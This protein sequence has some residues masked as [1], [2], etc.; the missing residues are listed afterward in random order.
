MALP[1]MALT[2]IFSFLLPSETSIVVFNVSG[3][4][5]RSN[6]T[7]ICLVSA[8][9]VTPLVSDTV[10]PVPVG[11]V[12]FHVSSAVPVL[13]IVNTFSVVSS[14]KSK[15]SGEI[16]IFATGLVAFTVMLSW[17]V[18]SEMMNVVLAFSGMVSR[19]SFTCNTW[20]PPAATFPSIGLTVM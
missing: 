16:S 11:T 8:G 2:E 3:I 4:M 18:P 1:F 17:V 9:L 10:K 13:L 7:V 19:S 14:P 12:I 15:E 20:L 6:V 5:E